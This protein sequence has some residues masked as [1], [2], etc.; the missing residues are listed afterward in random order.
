MYI[1]CVYVCMYVCMHACM[2]VYTYIYMYIYIYIYRY[3][4]IDDDVIDH[5]PPI[6]LYNP[7]FDHGMY[8]RFFTACMGQRTQIRTIPQKNHLRTVQIC[9]V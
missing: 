4:W 6:W 1:I 7:T 3:Q 5:H 2:Y 8:R 9:Y